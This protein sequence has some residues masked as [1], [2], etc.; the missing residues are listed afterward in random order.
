MRRRTG[1]A[2]ALA[3]VAVLAAAACSPSDSTDGGDSAG[4]KGQVFTLSLSSDPGALDPAMSA[5]NSLFTIEHLAYDNLVAVDADGQ[6][7]DQLASDWTEAADKLTF[8]IRDGVTC[9]DGS[10]LTAQT[11]ADNINFVAD[12]ANESPLLGAWVPVG[13]EASAAGQELTVNLTLP[14]PFA[15]ASLSELAIVCDAGLADR[16]T[17]AAATNG[18]GP[19]ELTEA[20][21]GDHYTFKIREGYTW[22]PGGATTAEPGMPAEVRVRIIE[23]ETTV[24]NMLLSGEVNAASI[25]GAD[26]ERLDAQ[27]MFFQSNAAL[28][29]Q[30]WYNESED[31]ATADPA[32]RA[33]LAQAVD[34]GQ[35]REVITSGLGTAPTT[36]STVAPVA[37]PGESIAGALPAYDPEAARSALEAAGYAASADGSRAKDGTPLKVVFVH[38]SALGDGAAAA[39]ELATQS[40]EAVGVEV[41]SSQL[42]TD[43]MEG[44]LV[45]TGAWDVAWEPLN[46][47]SP[48]Q[49][50][51]FFS[52]P[53][54]ADGGANFS[55][56]ANAA[57]DSLVGKASA[58]MGGAGCADWLAAETELIKANDLTV[59]ANSLIKIYGSGAEFEIGSTIFPTSIRMVG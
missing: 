14:A 17:L 53:G 21:P 35:L 26:T 47:S 33:A 46:T 11:V 27:E 23:N 40:W 30:Q 45:G 36:L 9:S 7:R 1:A 42:P 29:G 38:D 2:A 10:S 25:L 55:S 31:H 54:V 15:L 4:S 39:A 51:S 8:T 22:G 37:C 34:L 57:Y 12:P 13:A 59:F 28:I 18:S 52:G 41:E 24:A 32:V 20:V 58:Q 44:V 49:L 48:D 56:I 6:V 43:Q 3:A 5:S 16:S 50:T 19:Y